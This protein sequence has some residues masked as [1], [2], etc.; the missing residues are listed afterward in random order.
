[1][2]SY[3][4]DC[5]PTTELRG[6][7]IR[8]IRLRNLAKKTE[9]AYLSAVEGLARHYKKAPDLLNVEEIKDYLGILINQGLSWNSINVK[10]C[11]LR[12]FYFQTLGWKRIDL[13]LPPRKRPARLPVALSYDEVSRLLTAP[14]K[15]RDRVIL[16]TAYST[17]MRLGEI[18]RLKVSD[19][20][21]GR[22]LVRVNQ[23]KGKKDRYTLLS[24][25]LLEDLRI[26]WRRRRPVQYMFSMR[27]GINQPP[28]TSTIG[29]IYDKAKEKAG[30]ERGKGIHTLRH[31]FATHLL[32][33]GV[34]IR[35]IQ[36]LMGH[37]SL[38]TTM[39]YLHI[40]RKSFADIPNP[41]DLLPID[42]ERVNP[43]SPSEQ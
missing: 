19:I 3:D 29:R 20:E 5:R 28:D 2:K 22:M 10:V 39:V 33:A 21:S 34:D 40:C 16:K 13:P 37:K 6:R 26:Y 27:P 43:P 7:M 18:A 36:E 9:E 24:P 12:F 14:E 1:M 15:L 30:V 42:H 25:A 8:E 4:Y 41:L 23:G 17:G 11:G 31:T 32:D 38:T 35:T